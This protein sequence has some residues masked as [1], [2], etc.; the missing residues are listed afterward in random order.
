MMVGRGAMAKLRYEEFF[1][2]SRAELVSALA[3]DDVE[4]IRC[5]LFSASKFEPDWRWTQSQCMKF[6]DH[7]NHMVR[8]AAALSLGFTAVY[9]RKLDLTE[10]LPKLHAA[11]HD[12][13]IASVVDDSLEMIHQYI[14]AN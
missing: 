1:P 6:L 9:Q 12:A 2:Q 4:K 13:L 7:A 8:L 10:V 3:S 14:K 11:K 5:A